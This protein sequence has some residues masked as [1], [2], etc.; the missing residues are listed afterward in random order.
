MKRVTVINTITGRAYGCELDDPTAWIAEQQ[1]K[2]AWGKPGEFTVTIVDITADVEAEKTAKDTRDLAM[3]T[4]I[5]KKARTLPEA[6]ELIDLLCSY[7]GLAG[8]K[9]KK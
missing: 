1:L 9:E 8:Q 4:L 3:K 6:N 5:E 7:L 2:N